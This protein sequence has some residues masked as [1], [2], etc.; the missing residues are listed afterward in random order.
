MPCRACLAWFSAK[1]ALTRAALAFCSGV[2][3]TPAREHWL[4]RWER[5]RDAADDALVEALQRLVVDVEAVA[6]T[7]SRP[8]KAA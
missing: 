6:P 7:A 8:R 3:D 5:A 4:T 1:R 2:A